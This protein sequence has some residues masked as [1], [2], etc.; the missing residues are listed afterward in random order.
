MLMSSTNPR[1][2]KRVWAALLAAGASLALGGLASAATTTFSPSYKLAV[3]GSNLTNLG[4][5]VVDA[6]NFT[7]SGATPTL[8]GITFTAEDYRTAGAAIGTIDYDYL[9]T[10]GEW[11]L[12]Y[13]SANGETGR[14][15]GRAAGQGILPTDAIYG[16]SNECAYANCSATNVWTLTLS[17][18]TVGEAYT[19]QL[20]FSFDGVRTIT[21]T[22]VSSS[23]SVN[24]T[25]GG[26]AGTQM[27]PGTF[28]ADATTEAYTFSGS[29]N[30]IAGFTLQTAAVPE[31][32]SL[33]MLGLGGLALL[34]RRR[35]A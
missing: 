8:N 14:D 23:T 24:V 17:N 5:T 12:H 20:G 27:L 13:V 10:N 3:D 25:Y 9:G 29:Y 35:R 4:G 28:T 22:D 30:D 1:F 7:H 2:S 16:F 19:M 21:V 32:A 26:G 31:P 15:S 34:A 33:A 6:A 11:D 18:L